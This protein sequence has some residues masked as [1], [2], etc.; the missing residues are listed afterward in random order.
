MMGSGPLDRTGEGRTALSRLSLALIFII[1]G[2]PKR[3]YAANPAD[4]FVILCSGGVRSF[5][6]LFLLRNLKRDY[7]LILSRRISIVHFSYSLEVY[8]P[9]VS[10]WRRKFC[11]VSHRHSYGNR[12]SK[13]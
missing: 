2:K 4:P 8:A 3:F 10:V 6:S 9:K 7:F 1:S 11:G 5:S 13:T 12:L